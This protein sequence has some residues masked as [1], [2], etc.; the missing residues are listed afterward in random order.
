MLNFLLMRIAFYR[1][2]N[3]IMTSPLLPKTHT[4]ELGAYGA[5]VVEL[6]FTWYFSVCKGCNEYLPKG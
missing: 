6:R 4:P 1:P 3:G 2:N 5:V